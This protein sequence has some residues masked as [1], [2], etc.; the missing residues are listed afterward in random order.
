MRRP[1]I[2][3]GSQ[4]PYLQ[5]NAAGSG[6]HDRSG[7]VHGAR[8]DGGDGGHST[9]EEFDDTQRPRARRTRRTDAALVLT[10]TARAAMRLRLGDLRA[11]PCISWL[12]RS[13]RGLIPCITLPDAAF[14]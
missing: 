8:N 4:E 9:D 5:T 14:F 3:C 12:G 2:W 7:H 13:E 6:W 1:E 10:A 11:W